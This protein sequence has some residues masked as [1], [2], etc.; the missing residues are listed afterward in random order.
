MTN[1]DSSSFEG[2]ELPESDERRVYELSYLAVSTLSEVQL[3]EAVSSA[4]KALI[5]NGADIKSEDAPEELVL[6]YTMYTRAQEKNIPHE[7]AFFG[8]YKFEA[9]PRDAE[10]IRNVVLPTFTSFIRTLLFQTVAADTRAKIVPEKAKE[11]KASATPKA[12][13]AEKVASAESDL[14]KTVNSIVADIA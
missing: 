4:R 12:A 9:A 7:K 1:T 14:D 3:E 10:K 5:G 6:A 13:K 11:G 2:I 8:S